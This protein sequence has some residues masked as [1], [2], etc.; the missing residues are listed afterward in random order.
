MRGFGAAQTAIAYEGLMDRLA[1]KLG[2]DKTELR[3]K[4]LIHSGDAVTTGQIVPTPSATRLFACE[5]LVV[6]TT[7]QL[8]SLE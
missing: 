7:R 1:A 5:K 2:M 3:M 6:P 4:N 8:K